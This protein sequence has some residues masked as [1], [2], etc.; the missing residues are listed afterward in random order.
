[1]RAERSNELA[2]GG[3]SVVESEQK[4]AEALVADRSDLHAGVFG[5]LHDAKRRGEVAAVRVEV[6]DRVEQR[7]G[8][9]R[10]KEERREYRLGIETFREER[11]EGC[12][13][14]SVGHDVV[15]DR[16]RNSPV[17]LD[18][19]KEEEQQVVSAFGHEGD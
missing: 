1:M 3:R 9:L 17:C 10:K 7:G 5:A 19:L 2:I 6:D 18:L 12:V 8:F 4:L 16:D 11:G 15:C 14:N 13:S